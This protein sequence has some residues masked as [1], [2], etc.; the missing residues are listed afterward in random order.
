MCVFVVQVAGES[1]GT[2]DHSVSLRVVPLFETLDDLDAAQ[3]VM[4]TLFENEW[5]RRHLTFT[6]DNHQEVRLVSLSP[7]QPVGVVVVVC[8]QN[9][10]FREAKESSRFVFSALLCQALLIAAHLNTLTTHPPATCLLYHA[11]CS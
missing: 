5:Y 6:H 8:Q 2:P 3:S 1:R 9:R 4:N 11:A 7:S 10:G